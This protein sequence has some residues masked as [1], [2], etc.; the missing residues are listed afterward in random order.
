[1]TPG[2]LGVYITKTASDMVRGPTAGMV[3]RDGGL[4]G[5]YVQGG[6]QGVIGFYDVTTTASA[7]TATNANTL[8]VSATAPL[9]W[10]FLPAAFVNGLYLSNPG[11]LPV[12]CVLAG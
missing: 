5:F 3:T 9:G 12:T 10:N 2:S 8:L 1:M 11:G 6:T 4:L 7:A